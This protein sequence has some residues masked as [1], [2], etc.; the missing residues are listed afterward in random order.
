MH[1]LFETFAGYGERLAL[2]TGSE[3]ATYHQLLERAGAWDRELARRGIG[4]GQSVAFC[5]DYSV[6]TSA[7]ILALLARGNIAVPLTVAT[8]DNHPLYLELAETKA[9]IELDDG[10]HWRLS[11]R[12]DKPD[13]HPLLASLRAAERPG[14][15]L[16][17]SGSTGTPKAIVHDLEKLLAKIPRGKRAWRSLVFLLLDHI[18][19][20]NSLLRSLLN[21]GTAISI[22]DRA[23]DQVC[24]AI[25]AERI[26]L[27]PTSPTFL[28]MLLISRL[29]EKYDLSSLELI[30]YGTE[31]MPAATLRAVHRALPKV[32]L[33]QTYGLSE[34]G[35]FSTQSEGSESLWMRIGRGEVETKIVDGTLRVR[36]DTAMLGYLNAPSP[37]D[38]EGWFDTGDQVEAR[39]DLVR[40]L[41]RQSDVINVGG[42]K[43]YPA[44]VESVL[45]EMDNIRDVAVRGKKSPITGQ[46]VMVTVALH[47]PEDVA[48]LKQRI[49]EHCSGRLTRNM[50]PA[51][52][53]VV[54]DLKVTD[55]FK[56]VRA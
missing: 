27:L 33:K 41:G 20:I 12:P 53:E 1:W 13:A 22:R 23:P 11:T 19:G 10:E 15:V 40:I 47:A 28:N 52:V 45:L 14:L 9:L 39:G 49:W 18:G 44:E 32:R 35:I 2:C 8:R 26:E 42:E 37:F 56:K 30:T 54:Q 25:A 21:G 29:Y 38:A 34:F 3:T 31:V 51:V 24:A 6:A 5:G 50:V 43:V 17:S 55:R 46:V 36:G 16:F 48:A 4:P 7:L